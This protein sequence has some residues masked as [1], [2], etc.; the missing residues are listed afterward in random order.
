MIK[1]RQETAKDY[2]E[3]Y[4]LVKLAFENAE[5]T[6]GDEQNL[7]SR[8]RNSDAYIPE[9]SLV[10]EKNGKIVGHIMF[11]KTNVNGIIQLT[12]APL[13]IHIEYQRQGIGGMLIEEGHKIGEQLGYE[14]SI[15]LGHPSY[16]PKFGYLPAANFGIKSPFDVPSECFMAINLKGKPTQLN[17][18][19]EYP[20][21]FFEKS[22]T[23]K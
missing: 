23:P 19:V 4:L 22:Q 21:A 6:D 2:D 5:H 3:I 13:S 17:G 12:L 16:Y 9:L 8:L 7:V 10:A 15:L 18:T 1:I 20:K 14:F 11:T